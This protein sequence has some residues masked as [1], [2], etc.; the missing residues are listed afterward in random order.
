MRLSTG[1]KL[2]TCNLKEKWPVVVIVVVV[3]VVVVVVIRDRKEQ[4]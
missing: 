1:L 4:S 2:Q 3:V